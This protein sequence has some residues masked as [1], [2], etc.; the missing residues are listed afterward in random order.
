MQRLRGEI[1]AKQAADAAAEHLRD[2]VECKKSSGK[3]DITKQQFMCLHCYWSGEREFMHH[4]AAF[5]VRKPSEVLSELLMDGDWT[6]CERCQ[7]KTHGYLWH[8][9][10]LLMMLRGIY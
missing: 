10:L 2:E 7:K 9:K 5:G 1:A 3:Y 8:L 6:R 4:A